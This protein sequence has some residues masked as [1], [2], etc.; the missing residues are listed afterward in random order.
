M[1]NTARE[2]KSGPITLSKYKDLILKDIEILEKELTKDINKIEWHCFNDV[3]DNVE[4]FIKQ[5]LKIRKMNENLFII[6]KY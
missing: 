2:V 5:E 1:E 3:D 4:V 6:K